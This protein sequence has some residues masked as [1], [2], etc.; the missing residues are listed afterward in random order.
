MKS[1]KSHLH[2]KNLNHDQKDGS[3]LWGVGKVENANSGRERAE[4]EGDLLGI[5]VDRVEIGIGEEN[6]VDRKG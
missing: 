4:A 6:G 2:Q 3:N 1:T 5:A